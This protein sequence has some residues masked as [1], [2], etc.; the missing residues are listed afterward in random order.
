MCPPRQLAEQ[1]IRTLDSLEHLLSF[2]TQEGMSLTGGLQLCDMTV[3][4]EADA[5]E[6]Y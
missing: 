3:C 5:A 2:V 6:S 4:A 1:F